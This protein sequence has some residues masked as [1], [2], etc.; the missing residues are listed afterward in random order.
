MAEPS[1]TNPKG[2]SKR[3]PMAPGKAPAKPAKAKTGRGSGAW[4]T[5]EL[6]DGA[7]AGAF[8]EEFDKMAA[9]RV[10][11]AVAGNRALGVTDASGKRVKTELPEGMTSD[12]YFPV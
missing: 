1:V 2:R 6:K 11:E 4:A 3:L 8:F 7:A 10:R 9:E 12:T 5:V